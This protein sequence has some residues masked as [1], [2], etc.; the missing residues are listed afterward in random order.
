MSRTFASTRVNPE[1]AHSV[2]VLKTSTTSPRS[3]SYPEYEKR[4]LANIGWFSHVLCKNH[5]TIVVN[6]DS[7]GGVIT[8]TQTNFLNIQPIFSNLYRAFDFLFKAQKQ[9]Y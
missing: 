5:V 2:W 1:Y 8:N 9:G 7:M 4:T 6:W 3:I